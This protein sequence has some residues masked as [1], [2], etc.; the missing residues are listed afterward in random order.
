[1]ASHETPYLERPERLEFPTETWAAQDLRKAAVFEFA[2][3]H[4]P[5]TSERNH[6]LVRA[7][8]FFNVAMATLS[9]RSTSG[10]TRPLVLLLA[11][12]F[13]RPLLELG[14]VGLTGRPAVDFGRPT[15]FVAYKRRV[16]RRALLIGAASAAGGVMVVVLGMFL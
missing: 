2:A 9:A 10:L 16:L 4:T 5:I 13:Q 15:G 14:D 7:A 1:M 8:Y 6:L 3:R 12:G 11:Y